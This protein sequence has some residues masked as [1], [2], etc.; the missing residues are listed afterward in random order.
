MTAHFLLAVKL[1]F[2][3]IPAGHAQRRPFVI[4]TENIIKFGAIMG[5]MAGY[6]G[7]LKA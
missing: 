1:T 6:G 7:V 3:V 5:K 4:Y 2:T